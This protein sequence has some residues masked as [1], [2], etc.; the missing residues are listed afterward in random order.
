MGFDKAKG[1]C[2]SNPCG[3]CGGTIINNRWILTARVLQYSKIYFFSDGEK[4]KKLQQKIAGP[5]WYHKIE[6]MVIVRSENLYSRYSPGN[7][8]YQR[9]L[10]VFNCFSSK[11]NEIGN[12]KVVF[13]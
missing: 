3:N 11:K 10:P 8:D 9:I 7:Q 2:G 12:A 13:L 5:F 1:D 4:N 6:N